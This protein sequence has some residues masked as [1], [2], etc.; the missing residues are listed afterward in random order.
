MTYFHDIDPVLVHIGPVS[1]HWYGLMYLCGFGTSY[2]LG[3]R[4]LRAGRLGISAEQFSDLLFGAMLGVIIGGRIGYMLIYGRDELMAEPLSLFKVWEGGMSF[5]GGLVGVVAAGVWWSRKRGRHA[6]DVVDFMAPL[7]PLGL[8]FGRMGN[9]IGGELWGRHT[10]V[11][12]GVIFPKS[13]DHLGLDMETLRTQAEAGLLD[14]Q[15]RH[16]SQLYQV[17]LE[18]VVLFLIVWFYSAKPRRR[19]A[20]SGVFAIVYGLGRFLVEFV[21]EPDRQMGFVAFDW[22]TTGQ[23]LSLPL[24]ALGVAFLWVSRTQPVAEYT[25]SVDASPPTKSAGKG[26]A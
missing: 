10:D 8:G 14:A 9:W 25:L 3:M 16:P 11:S 26:K 15:A 19:Y 20:V 24:I 13:L 23:L 7:V 5:H 6:F 4:R 21:R 2:W 18:G 1:V 17:F 12:W 22:M